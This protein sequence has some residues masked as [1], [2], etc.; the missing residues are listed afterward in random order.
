MI[1][2]TFLFKDN[3]MRKPSKSSLAHPLDK[4]LTN[5]KYE[6]MIDDHNS[7]SSDEEN[8]EELNHRCNECEE[9]NNVLL[10]QSDNSEGNVT[11]GG[12]FLRSIIWDRDVTFREI[13]WKYFY[14]SHIGSGYG[15]CTI[16]FDGYYDRSSTNDH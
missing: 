15:L 2:P 7:I 5:Y 12:Y 14:M 11:N 10:P 1:I 16:V 13:T 8:N 4:N 6:K 9:E 3:F